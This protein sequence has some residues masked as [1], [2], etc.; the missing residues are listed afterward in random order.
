M[1]KEKL[2][3]NLSQRHVSMIALGGTIGTGLFLGAGESIQK[4]GPAILLIYI[5]TGFFIF[6]MMRALGELL[7]SDSS[8]PVFI[9]FMEQYLGQRAGFVLGWTYWLGWII[10]AMAEL[11]A[12][13][14]YMHFWFPTTPVWIWELAFLVIL[15]G[16]N[17][18]AV[19]AFGE[20]EFWFSL[21]KIFAIVAMIVVG[22][23]MAAFQM[24]T[25]VGVTHFSTLWQH[26]LVAHHGHQLLAAFQ[27]AFFA[28]LGVE[29]VGITAAETKDPLKTIPKAID[30]IV[31][32]ILIFY[33]GA[34]SAIMIIQPWTD[35][36]GQM[37]PFVQVFSGIGIT[38]AA[39]IINFVV[40]TAAASSLNS[41]LFTTGRMLYSLSEGKGPFA[42]LNRHAIPMKA[43]SFS[44]VII[45]LVIVLNYIFPNDAFSLVT[46]TAS[47]TFLVIYGA[48]MVTHLKFRK[49]ANY[50]KGKH[51]FRLPGAPY[52]NYLTLI[53]LFGIFLIL[54]FTP[55]TTVTT[56]LA[57]IWFIVLTVIAFYRKSF[58]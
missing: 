12:I 39:G 42:K 36:S 44:A 17:I 52:T 56:V 41:S 27:M 8:K 54:L 4:A 3:R 11:T 35:Y 23:I 22:F 20:T 10:I 24:K 58:K 48:L 1:A 5:V 49:S 14:N 40:L 6:A 25:S 43:I 32:R 9:D 7:V 26:G 16:I 55:A 13:G 31:I 53:F 47:A 33:I 2:E 51:Y 18:T 30:S 19:E 29:F 50:R 15:Y 46:S 28:F 45:G 38:S 37:S 21:I 34:L 57:I